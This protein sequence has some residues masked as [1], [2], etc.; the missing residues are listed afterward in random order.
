M[1]RLVRVEVRR[2]LSATLA[3]VSGRDGNAVLRRV[4]RDSI[5]DGDPPVVGRDDD[6]KKY[7]DALKVSAA[8]KAKIFEGNA[9]KV[10]P[11]LAAALKK[12]KGKG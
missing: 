10:F 4:R 11:R 7:V 1:A 3:S 6:T 9:H 5:E 12:N 8:D 2:N